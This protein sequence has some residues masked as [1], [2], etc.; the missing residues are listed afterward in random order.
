[1]ID[2]AKKDHVFQITI[3]TNERN[4]FDNQAFAALGAALNT[5][6]DDDS[7]KVVQITGAGDKFFS[8][9]FE[10]T[11]FL[12]K[13]YDYILDCLAPVM[14]AT[15]NLLVFPKP[16]VTFLNGHCMGVGSVVA[17]FTDYRIM[18]DGKARFGFPESQIG[19]NFPSV[20]G[21]VLKELVGPRNARAILFSGKP[22]KAKE[23]L[24]LG[25]IDEALP[26]EEA[27]KSLERYCNQFRDM[28][29][30]SV[31]GIKKSLIDY[32]R[33]MAENLSQGDAE[34]LASTI[35]AA[36]GQEGMRS[37]IERRRPVFK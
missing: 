18:V 23:A 12:D 19:L 21:F 2:Q 3:N 11:M 6:R 7:V 1:M 34:R 15:S 4:T 37:I 14:E 33:P 30:E 31:L 25:L 32:L 17:L 24:E 13:S 26:E 22:Y 29:M 5:A 36:N 20:P 8:N 35:A 10:P 9:G 16:V 28:A 27:R